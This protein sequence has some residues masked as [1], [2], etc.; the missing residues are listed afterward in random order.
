MRKGYCKVTV[1]D[2]RNVFDNHLCRRKTWKDGYCKQH[3]PDSVAERGKKKRKRYEEE[4]K[5]SCWYQLQQS[6]ARLERAIGLLEECITT[7]AYWHRDGCA[8]NSG[9]ECDCWVKDAK[10]LIFKAS[11]PKRDEA[12]S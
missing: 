6:E 10:E 8:G 1:Y 9:G 4:R 7:E 5:N 2:P 11:N 3:H 12:N